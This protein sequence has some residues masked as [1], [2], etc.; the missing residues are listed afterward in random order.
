[1]SHYKVLIIHNENQNIEELLAPYDENLE[2]E[3]YLKYKHNDAIEMIKEEFVPF[4]DFLKEYSD[5][6][7]LE[8][9]VK[10][11]SAELLKDGDIYTTY[12]PNSKWDW[13][14]IGGRFDGE[15]MLTDE[16]RLNAVDEIKRKYCTDID[17][18][19]LREDFHYMRYVNSAP[20]KY[21]QWFTPSSPIEKEKLRRWW[22]INV[23][24]DELKDGE[25]KDEYF[26]WNPDWYKRRYKDADTYIKTKEMITFFAVITPDG[27]WYA[28]SN[29]GWW[30][31]TDGEPEDELK[32]DL[33][34]YDRFIKPNLDS[35]LICTIVDCHI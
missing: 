25:K 21:I 24:K 10:E 28:P 5:E 6:Q 19:N 8:W 23:E 18:K 30:A 3:P 13:Y 34:F 14:Q 31:C 35:D 27:K 1:M 16:G 20:L 32:W 26:F 11:Y 15:L 12:N 7:L 17:I 29:M 2:V 4:N 22:E 33:E 9:Y